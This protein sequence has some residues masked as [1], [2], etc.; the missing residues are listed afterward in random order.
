[1]I[2][3]ARLLSQHA[4]LQLLVLDGAAIVKIRAT[5]K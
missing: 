3:W 5:T 2:D 1:L 4:A